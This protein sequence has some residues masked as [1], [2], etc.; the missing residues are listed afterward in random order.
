MFWAIIGSSRTDRRT[1]ARPQHR[2]TK[3]PR[4]CPFSRRGWAC[5]LK[6]R[7]DTTWLKI[8]GLQ[9]TR[10]NNIDY[11]DLGIYERRRSTTLAVGYKTALGTIVL[12]FWDGLLR[13]Y[14]LACALC[15]VKP[16]MPTLGHYQG[17]FASSSWVMWRFH[18][19]KIDISS[20]YYVMIWSCF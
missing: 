11:N 7:R 18:M 2:L 13:Y 3:R 6:N 10:E 16:H 12:E 1:R 8:L 5:H 4:I 20:Y 19:P 14:F 17:R 9:M 15:D